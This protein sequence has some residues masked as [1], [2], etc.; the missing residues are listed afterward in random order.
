M[1]KPRLTWRKQP[2]EPGLRGIGQGERGYELRHEGEHLG[3]AYP[4]FVGWGREK[5]GY[6]CSGRWDEMGVPH[7]N[8]CQEPVPTIEEA[9]AQLRAHFDQYLTLHL[10]KEADAS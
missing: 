4:S 3:G 7:L 1:K 5:V 10:K 8:T 9:K 6:Y 2:R